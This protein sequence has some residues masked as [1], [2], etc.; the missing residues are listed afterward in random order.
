MRH[1]RV[2]EL[3]WISQHQTFPSRNTLLQVKVM[4]L[5]SAKT[6]FRWMCDEWIL[7]SL[8][9]KLICKDA[10]ETSSGIR[11]FSRAISDVDQRINNC[12]FVAQEAWFVDP[13]TYVTFSRQNERERPDCSVS[14][15]C[16]ILIPH[17]WSVNTWVSRHSCQSLVLL[18]GKKRSFCRTDDV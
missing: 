8:D 2:S 7:K 9:P 5:K 12:T 17:R 3:S 14:K 16:G 18:R 1:H 15:P 11:C 13:W 6:M 4:Y 10:P